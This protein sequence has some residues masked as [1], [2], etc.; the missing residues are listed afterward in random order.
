MRGFGQGL[1]MDQETGDLSRVRWTEHG[2][3]HLLAASDELLVGPCEG[4]AH[5]TGHEDDSQGVGL[6][7][8]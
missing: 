8:A 4:Q 7:E 6:G 3:E 1:G 5:L 2:C